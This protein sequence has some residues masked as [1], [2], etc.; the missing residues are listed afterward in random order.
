MRG[1]GSLRLVNA[2]RGSTTYLPK[3]KFYMA[4]AIN[5]IAILPRALPR[6][7]QFNEKLSDHT[8]ECPLSVSPVCLD[9]AHSG[10]Y[11]VYDI[12]AHTP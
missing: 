2:K 3:P 11:L 9:K 10:R 8:G 1:L 4:F 12:G 6:G 5:A 7:Q